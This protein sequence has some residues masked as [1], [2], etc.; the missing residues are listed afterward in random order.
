MR[1]L[2]TWCATRA[3]GEKPSGSRSGD[4]SARLAG[5]FFEPQDRLLRCS[6]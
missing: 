3:L 6:I 1:Q 2:L 5:M 4:E